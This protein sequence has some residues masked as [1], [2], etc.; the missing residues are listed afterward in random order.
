MKNL[1]FKKWGWIYGPTSVMGWLLSLICFALIVW[2][3]ILVDRN[4]HSASDTLIGIFPWVW[5][6]LATLGWVASETSQ[7]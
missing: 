1:W 7:N 5:I 3:F 2:T 4:S 6:G